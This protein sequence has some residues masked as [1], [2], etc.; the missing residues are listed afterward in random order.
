MFAGAEAPY[1]VKSEILEEQPH[2]W[3]QRWS[4]DPPPGTTVNLGNG[5]VE[6]YLDR[7][8]WQTVAAAIA[9]WRERG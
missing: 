3:S 1:R 2:K 9:Q 4:D 5:L 6:I 7:G 8:I